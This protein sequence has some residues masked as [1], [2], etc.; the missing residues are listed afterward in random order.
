MKSSMEMRSSVQQVRRVQPVRR[1]RQV[2]Q[3]RQVPVHRCDGAAAAP[4]ARRCAADSFVSV[5]I[6]SLV[7]FDARP[8][9]ARVQDLLLAAR[10]PRGVGQPNRCS[11]QRPIVAQPAQ[12]LASADAGM[13]GDSNVAAMRTASADVGQHAVSAD[14][15]CVGSFASAHG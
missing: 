10:S 3:V 13:T 9:A 4:G 15:A 14:R 11:L 8:Q 2:R 5:T 12:D 1:V 7:G 6:D